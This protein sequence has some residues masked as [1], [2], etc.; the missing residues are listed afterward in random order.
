MLLWCKDRGHNSDNHETLSRIDHILHRRSQNCRCKCTDPGRPKQT[1]RSRCTKP[2]H[3]CTHPS[4]RDS[5]RS[6]WS[7]WSTL[8]LRNH[9]GICKRNLETSRSQ[10][11]RENCMRWIRCKPVCMMGRMS[12]QSRSDRIGYHQ[13]QLNRYKNSLEVSQ[14][15]HLRDCCSSRRRW[16]R[17]R[18]HKAGSH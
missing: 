17:C 10:N 12:S 18:S 14:K 1:F 5:L 13:S 16:Y 6:R 2:L 11:Q 9:D 7:S 3:C 4:R 8:H 15:P